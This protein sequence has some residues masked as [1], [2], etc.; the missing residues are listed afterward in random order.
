MGLI[1]ETAITVA[2][3]Q[4][5]CQDLAGDIYQIA[6]AVIVGA[7]VVAAH[8]EASKV[9]VTNI[10]VA[11]IVAPNIAIAIIVAEDRPVDGVHVYM[12]TACV[13]NALHATKAKHRIWHCH[14]IVHIPHVMW[15]WGHT[16]AHAYHMTKCKSSKQAEC[17]MAVAWRCIDLAALTAGSYGSKGSL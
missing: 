8:V 10:V 3:F 12:V 16:H 1:T 11:N 14:T 2:S 13:N 15:V 5:S 7:I 4:Q 6:S 9:V 17:S